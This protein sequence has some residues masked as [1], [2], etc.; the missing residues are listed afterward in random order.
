VVERSADDIQR[1]IE[2]ARVGL[3]QSVD[4]LTYRTSPQRVS[5]QI[6]QT[7]RAKAESTEGRIVIGVTG[8]V[9]VLLVVKRIRK[10]A[11]NRRPV[12]RTKRSSRKR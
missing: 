1:D 5:E 6:K 9:V 4:Q 10:A 8:G 11:A 3:A 12:P 2:Q 7:L